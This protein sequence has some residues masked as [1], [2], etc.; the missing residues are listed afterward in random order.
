MLHGVAVNGVNSTLLGNATRTAHR[1]VTRN[2]NPAC[3]T[4]SLLVHRMSLIHPWFRAHIDPIVH[5]AK[6][7]YEKRFPMV[8]VRKT[9]NLAKKL[10]AKAG[11][12]TWSC[13]RNPVLAVMATMARIG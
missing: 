7:M 4:S 6:V 8:E 10:H 5:W 1:A 12:A 3:Q 13:V 2:D 9:F 11:K